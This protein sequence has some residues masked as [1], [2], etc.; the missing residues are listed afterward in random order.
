MES[1]D[2]ESRANERLNTEAGAVYFGVE[3]QHRVDLG[4]SLL[5]KREALLGGGEAI[6]IEGGGQ[7][8][9]F[10]ASGEVSSLAE[11][12][13]AFGVVEINSLIPAH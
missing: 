11:P 13:L 8:L 3:F 10:R 5:L 6:C 4:F 1:G 12:R 9:G 2:N 7:R